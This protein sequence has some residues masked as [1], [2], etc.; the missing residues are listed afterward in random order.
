VTKPARGEATSRDD[1]ALA[2]RSREGDPRALAALYR[3]SAPALLDYLERL[4]GD[5]AEAEDA[6]H[7][8]FLRLFRGRGRYEARG[9]FRSWLFTL[10]THLARDRLKQLR[11]QDRLVDSLRQAPALAAAGSPG[12]A[13]A[14]QE[15]LSEIES[16]LADLPPAYG[17]AFHLRVR[18]G[19]SYREMA[20]IQGEP[21]GTLRSRVH[22]TLKCIRQRLGERGLATPPRPQKG[23]NPA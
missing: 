10:A 8:S 14:E 11:R 3:R 4:L 16:A 7:E 19:F 6:L 9:R 1:D 2:A 23:V 22:H 21:E 18:E 12:E 20:A 17:T 5:R 13:V 15:L